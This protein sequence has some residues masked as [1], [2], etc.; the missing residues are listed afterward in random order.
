MKRIVSFFGEK[1]EIF[2]DL[3]E[4]AQEYASSL[5]IEY[6]W[7]PQNPFSQEEVIK[8]LQQ[9]DAGII[10][11][12]PYGEAVFSRI[13]E[14]AKL[15]VR[16]GV[17][18]DKVDL[19]AA[20]RNGIAVARTTGAN[21]TA[22]AEMALSLMLSCKR[23]IPK[24]QS[25]TRAGEWVKDIG[26]EMIGATVGIV[27][28]GAIGRRLARLL[29]GFDC[30]ILAYDPFPRKEVMEEDGVELASM[31]ELLCQADAVSIHVPLTEDTYHMIDEKALGLMKPEA[32]IVNTAR[33]GII[34]EEALYHAL[35]EG[36]LGAAGLDV[37]E[38]E[39]LSP[40]SPLLTLENAVLTPHVSSQTVE[41]LWNIYKM[42]IDISAG[43]FAGKGSPHILNPDYKNYI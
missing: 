8:E 17:G 5:G 43:F 16:F 41:S 33:G 40:D 18:Y 24:Y 4:R 10:D 7:V 6:R 9:A 12:E 26:H 35:K 30:R 19:E 29:S 28:Y 11:I 3:N 27:G 23:R 15:L 2:C 37:F 25:R 21:T 38:N 34:E 42:A 20:S 13:K 22:V 36:R 31:E 14:S 39:P 32:V 1:T